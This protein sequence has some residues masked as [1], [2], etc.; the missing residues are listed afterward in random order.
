[1]IRWFVCKWNVGSHIKNGSD[2]GSDA[3]L[4]V[5]PNQTVFTSNGLNLHYTARG[6]FLEGVI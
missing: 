2:D 3:I 6:D 4:V 5:F 1:M